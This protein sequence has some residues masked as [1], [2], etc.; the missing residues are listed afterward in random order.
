MRETEK[1][2]CIMLN[3]F[4]DFVI[5]GYL[6]NNS[7]AIDC[8]QKCEAFIYQSIQNS[9]AFVY[10]DHLQMTGIV[11]VN[12]SIC[13]NQLPNNW[14]ENKKSI[15]AKLIGNTKFTKVFPLSLWVSCFSNIP[16]TCHF[17]KGVNPLGGMDPPPLVRMKASGVIFPFAIR[18]LEAVAIALKRREPRR[19][20]RALRRAFLFLG[21]LRVL[22]GSRLL[23]FL[24]QPRTARIHHW[25]CCPLVILLLM[26]FSVDDWSFSSSSRRQRK[27][28]DITSIY[29]NTPA[30]RS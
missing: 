5:S 14:S 26:S 15:S 4:S 7:C 29:R 20:R 3:L 17:C 18:S 12:K 27:F 23:C 9:Q 25:W 30:K 16:T 13:L 8:S 22:R 1:N 21:A 10:D 2:Y 11:F 24:Q 19:T 28:T 6:D